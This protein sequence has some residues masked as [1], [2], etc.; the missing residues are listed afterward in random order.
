[1]LHVLGPLASGERLAVERHVADEVEWIEVLADLL[2][3]RL[4]QQALGFEFLHDGPRSAAF[5]RFR[6]SSRLAN[7]F[8]SAFL[9]ESRRHSVPSFPGQPRSSPRSA[10][11]VAPTPST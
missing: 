1:L 8:L 9:V 7:R 2:G 11:M 4:Q 5:H 3:D 6:K 10:M